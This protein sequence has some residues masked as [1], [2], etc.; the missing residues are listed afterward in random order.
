MPKCLACSL[1]VC[2]RPTANAIQ[3]ICH[4][5]CCC[6]PFELC[7]ASCSVVRERICSLDGWIG[8]GILFKVVV[9]RSS[10]CGS[11]TANGRSQASRLFERFTCSVRSGLLFFSVTARLWRNRKVSV[12]G[13]GLRDLENA[14]VYCTHSFVVCGAPTANVGSRGRR[15][16]FNSASLVHPVATL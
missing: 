5:G 8:T 12:G 14:G 10:C 15:L 1:V 3:T 6:V 9:A 4:F 7:C 11:F 2:R 16:F 13:W